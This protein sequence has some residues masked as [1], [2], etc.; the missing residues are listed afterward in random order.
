MAHHFVCIA[1]LRSFGNP[2]SVSKSAQ[3]ILPLLL[4]SCT[5]R[6]ERTPVVAGAS[7]PELAALSRNAVTSRR[8][9]TRLL[10]DPSATRDDALRTKVAA[11]LDLAQRGA[12]PDV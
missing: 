6:T 9:A 10:R 2:R 1:A 7:A 8:R 4:R 3:P 11:V 5:S 12:K